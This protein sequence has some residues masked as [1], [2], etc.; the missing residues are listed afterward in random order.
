MTCFQIASGE[1]NPQSASTPWTL[2][3]RS[4]PVAMRTVD[5][6]IETPAR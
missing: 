2:S 4:R 6:P 1:V 3:G 5:A